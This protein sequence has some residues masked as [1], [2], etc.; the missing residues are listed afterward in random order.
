MWLSETK[1]MAMGKRISIS[2]K[3]PATSHRVRDRLKGRFSTA[4][5]V[6]TA[7]SRVPGVR[8]Q[9][10]RVRARLR[11]ARSHLLGPGRHRS[12]DH[13][14]SRLDKR[15]GSLAD[16]QAEVSSGVPGND[17]GDPLPADIEGD[18]GQEADRLD[19]S[20]APHQLVS[21]ADKALEARPTGTGA[22]PA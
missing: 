12:D 2:P 14:L 1:A 3:A 20:D 13:D 6:S 21:P 18:L 19:L 17:G 16:L 22:G 8:F 4:A 10:V 15:G 9:E 11:V 5:T 7:R